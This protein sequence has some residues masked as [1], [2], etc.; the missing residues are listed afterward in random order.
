[1]QYIQEMQ[2]IGAYGMFD[3]YSQLTEFKNSTHTD[4]LDIRGG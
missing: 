3:K 4:S 1:L 2:G